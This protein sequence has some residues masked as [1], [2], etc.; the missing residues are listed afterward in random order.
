MAATPPRA[1]REGARTRRRMRRRRALAQRLDER[2]EVVSREQTL[3]CAE[4]GVVEAVGHDAEAFFRL[5][6]RIDVEH[7]LVR[8]K[9]ARL[10]NATPA[11]KLRLPL[12]DLDA[13]RHDATRHEERYLRPA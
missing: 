8:R 3:R 12:C 7:G 10:D 9:L 1:G 2:V 5:F 13:L 4:A 11:A 6:N